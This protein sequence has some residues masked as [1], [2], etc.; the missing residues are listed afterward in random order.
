MSFSRINGTFDLLRTAI[1][2]YIPIVDITIIGLF[3]NTVLHNLTTT[4][5]NTF[6][7]IQEFS[8]TKIETIMFEFTPQSP[9]PTINL[10][11]ICYSL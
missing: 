5:N 4:Y 2:P 10:D 7:S 3:N 9:P 11:D 1:F 6:V 8:V